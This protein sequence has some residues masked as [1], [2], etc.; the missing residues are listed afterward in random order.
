MRFE[1][2]RHSTCD[3]ILKNVKIDVV[4]A[5]KYLGVNFFKKWELVQNAEVTW[6][7][8][9]NM[10]SIF[11]QVDLPVIEKCKLFDSLVGSV[12]N[13]NSEE[14]GTCTYEAKASRKHAYIILLNP[15]FI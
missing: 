3:L 2:G 12:L 14:W 7:A 9:P 11:K 4:T 13:Y 1:K 6:H 15:T 10:F 8:L 5:F